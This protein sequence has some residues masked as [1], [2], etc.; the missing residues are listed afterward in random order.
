MTKGMCAEW[1]R[2][3]IQVNGLAPGYFE[4]ELTRGLVDDP[5]FSDW[6]RRRTPAGR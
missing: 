4:T 1:A 3:G 2:H 6:L 5:V